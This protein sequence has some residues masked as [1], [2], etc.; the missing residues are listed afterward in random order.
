MR[1]FSHSSLVKV[2]RWFI[3][4]SSGSFSIDTSIKPGRIARAP[5]PVLDT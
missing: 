2:L 3:E 5:R 4:I 1:A